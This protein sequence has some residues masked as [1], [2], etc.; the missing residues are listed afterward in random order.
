MT[1]VI[2]LMKQRLHAGGVSRSS[3]PVPESLFETTTPNKETHE[4]S[5]TNIQ[6]LIESLMIIVK[7]LARNP[8]RRLRSSIRAP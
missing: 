8:N 6:A 7:I 1:A 3:M 4:M 5:P 2:I